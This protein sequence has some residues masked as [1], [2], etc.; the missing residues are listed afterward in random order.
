MQLQNKLRFS[1]HESFHCRHFW[2]KKGYDFNK[3]H[4][5]GY[6]IN[7]AV[8]ELGVG[9][10]MVSSIDFWLKSFGLKRA[11]DSMKL[12]KFADNLF[13]SDNGWDPFLEYIGTLWLLQYYL[14]KTEYASLYNII[15]SKYRKQRISNEF[16]QN[17]IK[18]F[19]KSEIANQTKVS[20]NEN[21]ANTD[22]KVFLKTYLPPDTNSKS[23]EDDFSALFIDLGII[24]ECIKEDGREQSYKFLVNERDE[25]PT[26]I[27]LFTILDA[28]EV[29]N[30]SISFNKIANKMADYFLISK[31]GVDKKIK[32]IIEIYPR[33]TL[34][35]NGGVKELQLKGVEDKW[36]V[37]RRYYE[38]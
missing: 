34:S 9:K 5:D 23:V 21:T 15:F 36:D 20:Y 3:A 13:N 10:N 11:D 31:D 17:Q 29:D 1:G 26:E 37:L 32:K 16:N 38:G 35:D 18:Y 24:V 8:V 2:L 19:L 25:I 14:L 12:T 33:T 4:I 27:F 22:L 6:D 28:F 7:N 30:V